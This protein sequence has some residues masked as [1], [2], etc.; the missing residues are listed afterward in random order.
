MMRFASHP[1]RRNNSPEYSRVDVALSELLVPFSWKKC[2]CGRTA[3]VILWSNRHGAKP[4]LLASQI[5]HHCEQVFPVFPSPKG[6]SFTLTRKSLSLRVR[7]KS[8]S[9]PR[10]GESVGKPTLSPLKGEAFH[11]LR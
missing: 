10:P 8:L 9:E 5:T 1:T 7:S 2:G 6:E 3:R 4:N 11:V